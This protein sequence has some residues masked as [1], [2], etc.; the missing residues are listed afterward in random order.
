VR[1]YEIGILSEGLRI[2]EGNQTRAAQLL[3]IP[4]RTLTYKLKQYGLKP[5]K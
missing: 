2:A 3:Q 5:A 1:E 4:L